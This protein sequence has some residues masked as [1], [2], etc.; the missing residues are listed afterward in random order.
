MA[1]TITPHKGGRTESTRVR[2]TPATKELLKQLNVSAADLLEAAIKA[3]MNAQTTKQI[4]LAP[5]FQDGSE[6][7]YQEYLNLSEVAH[8]FAGALQ[9]V[10]P[11]TKVE[12]M[13]DGTE[14]GVIVQYT[15]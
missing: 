9:E 11:S 5:K 1:R 10:N 8:K 7:T 14:T 3:K 2:M 15:F 6:A 13:S 12:I 4:H